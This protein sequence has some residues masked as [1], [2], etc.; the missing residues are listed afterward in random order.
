MNNLA[1]KSSV[2]DWEIDTQYHLMNQVAIRELQRR[3]GGLVCYQTDLR[4]GCTNE[5]CPY[6]S[7]CMA[8][9]AAWLR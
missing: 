4:I 8:L 2:D 3:E 1:V 6:R 7:G 5:D 9:V